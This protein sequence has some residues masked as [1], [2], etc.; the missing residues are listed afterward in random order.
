MEN[1][2]GLS[3]IVLAELHKKLEHKANELKGEE[4]IFQLSQFVQE[5]L[6]YHNKP[7]SKSFY[8]EMLQRQK[9]KEQK[10]LQAKKNE[11]DRQVKMRE[12]FDVIS[13]HC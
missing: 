2:K 1:G 11:Q 7:S 8:D 10:D 9:E 3:H 5:F 6:H 13:N 4:M 12:Y